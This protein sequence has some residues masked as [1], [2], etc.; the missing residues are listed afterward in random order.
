MPAARAGLQREGGESL[1]AIVSEI[2]ISSGCED[3]GLLSVS[4]ALVR[5]KTWMLS[6]GELGQCRSTGTILSV[7]VTISDH[8]GFQRIKAT[9]LLLPST[10]AHF[11]FSQL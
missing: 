9:D 6:N 2:G 11:S 5:E 4:R 10:S 8:G 1:I 7:F 3:L